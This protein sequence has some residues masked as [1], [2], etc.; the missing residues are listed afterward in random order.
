MPP[1]PYRA[2]WLAQWGSEYIGKCFLN[3]VIGFQVVSGALCDGPRALETTGTF[4]A[5]KNQTRILCAARRDVTS[6]INP[7]AANVEDMVS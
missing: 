6:C 2:S 5:V 3:V 7:Y 4:V 1:L